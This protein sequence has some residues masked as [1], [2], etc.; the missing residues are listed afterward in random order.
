M[1]SVFPTV[2][3]NADT[4]YACMDIFI[5]KSHSITVLLSG[6]LKLI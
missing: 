6:G 2:Q 3:I 5:C 4:T 1:I